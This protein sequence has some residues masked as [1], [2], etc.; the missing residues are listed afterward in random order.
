MI[1]NAGW[2]QDILTD[3]YVEFGIS[4]KGNFKGFP[5]SC[6]LIGTKVI[7]SEQ[8]YEVSYHIDSDWNTGYTGSITITNNTDKT[9]NDWILEFDCDNKILNIWNGTVISQ[10]KN[11]YIV[12]NPG[13]NQNIADHESVSF[14]FIMDGTNLSRE[15]VNF[16]LSNY[17]DKED[18]TEENV[19]REKEPLQSIGEAY[20]KEPKEE[21]IV[22][23]KETGLKYAKNQ[24]LVSAYMGADKSIFEEIA[25]EVGAEIVGYIALTNDYQFEFTKDMTIEE[26]QV[27]ADYIDSFSFVSAVSLN[28]V[29]ENI[30]EFTTTDDAIYNDGATSYM[31]KVDIDK[32]GEYD[33]E[34]LYYNTNEAD[35]WSNET[36]DGD[37]WGLEA[38]NVPNAWDH[39]RDFLTVKVGVYDAAF[40]LN[41]DLIFDDIINNPVDADVEHGTHVSGILAAQHN[42]GIGISGIATDTRL[43]AYSCNGKEHGSSM[44]DK[45]AY[46]ILIGNH[47]KV[48]NVSL[49]MDC[50]IQYAASH[51]VTSAQNYIQTQ[52]D[53]IE[54]YLN[55][56]VMSGYDFV[57]V[58]SAGNSENVIF[59][60]DDSADYGYRLYNDRTDS[61]KPTYSGDVL[62][63]Y[64]CE[65]TSITDSNIRRRIIVV[66]AIAHS[67][68]GTSTTYNYASFSNVGSR[69]DICA[70][71]VNIVSTV[72]TSVDPSGYKIMSGTSMAS[73]YIAS[74]VAMM[75]QVNPA[76]NANRIK[77]YIRSSSSKKVTDIHGNIY[78]IPDAEKCYEYAFY[79]PTNDG[80]DNTIPSG[81]LCGYTKDEDNNVVPNVKLT[82]V[83][84]STGE[85]NLDNY[86]F[87]FESDDDGYY[88]KTL[89][90]GTYDIIIYADGYLPYSLNNI[91]IEPDQTYFMENIILNKWFSFAYY[92]FAVNG[93]VIDAL[94]GD[95][96]SD[97]TIKIRKGWNTTS[98]SYVKTLFGTVRTTSTLSDGKFMLSCN[99]GAYTVEISKKGYVTAHYNVVAG[100]IGIFSS[101]PTYTVA[102]TPVLAD[103]EYRIVLTW[104]KMPSDLD[105]HLT[106]YKDDIQKK[107]IYYGNKSSSMD[108]SVIAKLD[109]DD[110]SSYGP[111][112]ITI[113]LDSSLVEDGGV[114][115]YSV[116]NYTNRNSSNSNSLSLSN[117][118]VRIYAGNNLL[119]SYNV[120]M[121]EIGTVWHVFDI[122]ENG[123]ETVN[124]F[125]NASVATGV[126]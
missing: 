2:N 45:Y 28:V 46:A 84:H 22:F 59:V 30:T 82:A 37:N 61:D 103:D 15:V 124:E 50:T 21:D 83:R 102:L 60:R 126:R 19:E 120:P 117:A 89:P 1:S 80:N 101:L 86:S 57:I 98:G 6:K 26:I 29:K 58:T 92:S 49:G 112:T 55:K 35:V 74:L 90:Q 68:I 91:V 122:T 93:K 7:S 56:L 71:G 108:G 79:A 5:S 100:D 17:S 62:A 70:P 73:P 48:I 76:L 41:E 54:E 77:G 72:P 94:T 25:N 78:F 69:V 14:G 31:K 39:E 51:G 114:F 63:Q 3:S 106:Y 23:D 8:D 111:E 11:H 67:T 34:V 75:Y 107:H 87:T 105:S 66:G 118:T 33:Y 95:N 43:Y 20:F 85:Y 53:I 10:E 12:Q 27:I 125:Y 119:K 47:V 4:G 113:T 97:A 88:L 64:D 121:N 36:P 104:G 13:Y 81:I 38:L 9:I 40:G 44:G 18:I 42:N 16:V 99:S 109:L 96:I 123:I 24:L 32:D 65:L 52:A 110:T 115:K 116:H